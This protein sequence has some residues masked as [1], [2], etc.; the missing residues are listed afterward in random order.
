MIALKIHT[1]GYIL[2]FLELV[3]KEMDRRLN[4]TAIKLIE[5]CSIFENYSTLL[6][7]SEKLIGQLYD[8]LSIS[9]YDKNYI[10]DFKFLN[11]WL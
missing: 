5:G 9:E 10:L 3:I 11:L 4:D 2:S 1:L 7:A 6:N 8:C